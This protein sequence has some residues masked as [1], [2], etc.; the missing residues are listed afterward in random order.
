M[1][2]AETRCNEIFSVQTS[3]GK[4][5]NVP[6]TGWKELVP[7]WENICRAIF[8][9]LIENDFKPYTATLK[10][11]KGF[12]ASNS[13]WILSSKIPKKFPL[14]EARYFLYKL[15]EKP[16]FR[17]SIKK[18][19]KGIRRNWLDEKNIDILGGYVYS[20]YYTLKPVLETIGE[21]NNARIKPMMVKKS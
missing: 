3:A 1:K 11:P 18:F 10:R 13:Y 2:E 4:V 19:N 5:E 8:E 14:T 7:F 16:Y 17:D 21:G 20:F 9:V 15:L 12:V 6:I